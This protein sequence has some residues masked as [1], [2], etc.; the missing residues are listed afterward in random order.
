[1]FFISAFYNQPKELSLQFYY[2]SSLYIHSLIAPVQTS[3]DVSLDVLHSVMGE[4]ANKDLP[5]QVQDFIHYVPQ[6]VKEIPLIPL[7]DK[8]MIAST[9]PVNADN[10][11][12]YIHDK[13][14]RK[15][16]FPRT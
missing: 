16:L 14:F 1:M 4:M 5:P 9:S 6:P 13:E 11:N 7:W 8:N 10:P 12:K 3:S 2:F 15:T